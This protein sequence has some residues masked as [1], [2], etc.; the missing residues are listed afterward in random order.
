M[1]RRQ[2]KRLKDSLGKNGKGFGACDLHGTIPKV[3]EPIDSLTQSSVILHTVK[4]LGF[5]I[6]F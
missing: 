5:E 4:A 2:E 3:P 1:L 6:F